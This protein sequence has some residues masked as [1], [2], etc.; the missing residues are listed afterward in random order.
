M[1]LKQDLARE[2]IRNLKAGGA[3]I[4]FY[5]EWFGDALTEEREGVVRELQRMGTGPEG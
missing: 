1:K 3:T 4:D 5:A 2:A